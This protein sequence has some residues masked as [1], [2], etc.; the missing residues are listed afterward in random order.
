MSAVRV[1]N[2]FELPVLKHR[3]QKAITITPDK[4]RII[5]INQPSQRPINRGNIT[6]LRGEIMDG[7]FRL[8][9]QG[10]AF[11]EDGL[12]RDGQHRLLACLECGVSIDVMASFNEPSELFTCYDTGTVRKTGTTLLLSGQVK[13]AAVG[14]AVAAATKFIWAYNNEMNPAHNG[15]VLVGWNF[16]VLNKVLELNPNILHFVAQLRSHRRVPYQMAPTA[17][18]FT[19]FAKV[20]QQ[21]A[22][23]FIEQCLNGEN[24]RKGD[25]AYA[26]RESLMHYGQR[27]TALDKIYKVARAWNA[28]YEGRRIDRVMGATRKVGNSHM[29]D[30]YDPFPEIAGY[31]REE[32][33]RR[34]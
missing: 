2:L 26:L 25:P 15:S 21:K 18:M 33:L 23:V 27:Q 24:I 11:D 14:N 1:E 12:L 4:A 10:I 6:K 30:G 17:A 31:K 7:R 19:M 28:F 13:S 5:L 22:E 8:T 34:A 32:S 29:P 20:D 3:W 16:E 9:H